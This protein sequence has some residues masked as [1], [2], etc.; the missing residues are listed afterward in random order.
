MRG[1]LKKRVPLVPFRST[2]LAILLVGGLL[3]LMLFCGWLYAGISRT[4][5]SS[6]RRLPSEL[7]AGCHHLGK[8]VDRGTTTF[9][10][11][12]MRCP[13][14]AARPTEIAASDRWKSPP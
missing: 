6:H 13:H 10:A 7:G 3:L 2:V 4:S 1:N 9:G 5:G 12:M 8:W 11:K 14:S